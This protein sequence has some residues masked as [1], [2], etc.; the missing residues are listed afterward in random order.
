MSTNIKIVVFC[1]LLFIVISTLLNIIEFRDNYL[2]FQNLFEQLFDQISSSI[3]Q[4]TNLSDYLNALRESI[5][6]LMSSY[7]NLRSV[8]SAFICTIVGIAL[9]I[10]PDQENVIEFGKRLF[11][12]FFL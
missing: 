8:G 12:Y 11:D 10:E 7:I 1:V 2:L 5:V 6:N 3:Y 4:G 9:L